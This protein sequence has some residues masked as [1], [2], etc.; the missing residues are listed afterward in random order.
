[1]K[2]SI[3]YL[4]FIGIITIVALAIAFPTVIVNINGEYR[5]IRGLDPID[6]K[7]NFIVEQYGFQPGLDL[8]G[9]K[10]ITLDLDMTKVPA[11]QRELEFARA[12]EILFTRF[13]YTKIGDFSISSLKNKDKP[14]QYQIMIKLP[15]Y[16][17][18]D[19]LSLLVSRGQVNI[20]A[21]DPNST[22]KPEDIKS[23]FDG[24]KATEI[25]NEDFAQVS[26]VSDS[27]IFLSDA[28]KPNNFGLKVTFKNESFSKFVNAL[29]SVPRETLPMMVVLDNVP[30]AVKASGQL[31]S[32][33][34]PGNE[35]LLYTVVPD[36]SIYNSALAAVM[37]TPTIGEPISISGTAD[38]SP[39]LGVN[40]LSKIKVSL[41][42][43]F[44]LSQ[45][46]MLI[47]FRKRGWF[48]V[49]SMGIFL[50]WSIALMKMFN[51]TLNMPLISGFLVALVAF[52]TFIIIISY[53]IRT[54][55]K[56]NITGDELQGVYNQSN[57]EFRNLFI[58]VIFF[59]LVLNIYGLDFMKQF[60]TGLG[61]GMSAGLLMMLAGVKTLLP[62]IFLAKNK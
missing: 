29:Y 9:G 45:V 20:W 56:G 39:A 11:E 12:Q 57:S 1:M 5:R 58:L 30:I 61:F 60:A 2:K 17:E 46:F 28:G 55:F 54:K 34:N 27:R 62:A 35:L 31:F 52:S 48:N 44:V 37:Q 18:N 15:A 14:D 4:A 41:L 42:T 24:R 59:A 53:R 43:A 36:V 38:F 6:F 26:V 23:P 21:E 22:I 8:Q 50:I 10:V 3:F 7:S 49:L 19:L 51:V 47:Y 32:Q 13:T 16:V 40:A 33:L 25:T